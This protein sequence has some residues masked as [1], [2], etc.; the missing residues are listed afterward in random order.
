MAEVRINPD[1]PT[2]DPTADVEMGG[3][4]DVVEVGETGGAEGAEDAEGEE[5]ETVGE[6]E[7][8][9]PARRVTFVESVYLNAPSR[10]YQHADAH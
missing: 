3:D 2:A 9:K 8:P 1:D 6:D 4:D 5:P 7:A 10:E